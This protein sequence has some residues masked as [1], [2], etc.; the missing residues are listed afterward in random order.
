MIERLFKL[1]ENYAL[2][3]LL[4]EWA[5]VLE[6]DINM[7]LYFNCFYKHFTKIYKMDFEFSF[8]NYYKSSN[9]VH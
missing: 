7:Q 2:Q 4:V 6:N 8:E 1:Y 5:F 9:K 3:K